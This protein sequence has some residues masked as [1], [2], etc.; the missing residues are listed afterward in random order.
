MK[1]L[2]AALRRRCGVVVCP[3]GTVGLWAVVLLGMVAPG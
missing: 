1:V 3:C 2:C